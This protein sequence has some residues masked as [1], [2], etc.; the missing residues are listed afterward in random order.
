MDLD[1][2]NKLFLVCGASSGLGKA[3]ASTLLQEGAKIIAVARNADRLAHLNKSSSK[4]ETVIGDLAG[5]Q[6]ASKYP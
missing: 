5:H 3:I 2:D 4:V 6:N 1:L